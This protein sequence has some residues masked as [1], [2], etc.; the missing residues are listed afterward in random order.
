MTPPSGVRQK[1]PPRRRPH[2]PRVTGRAS[3]AGRAATSPTRVARMHRPMA[4]PLRPARTVTHRRASAQGGAPVADAQVGPG[5][6]RPPRPSRRKP[7]RAAAPSMAAA[8]APDT[9]PAVVAPAAVVVRA[10]SSSALT[11][12]TALV[13]PITAITA[14]EV[15]G[16]KRGRGRKSGEGGGQQTGHRQL[17]NLH[18]LVW[19]PLE[20]SPRQPRLCRWV[21]GVWEWGEVGC[22]VSLTNCG[23]SDPLILARRRHHMPA[24]R[25]HRP[26]A[27]TRPPHRAAPPTG[28]RRHHMRQ[29]ASPRASRVATDQPRRSPRGELPPSVSGGGGR[30][31]VAIAGAGASCRHPPMVH[32]DGSARGRRLRP[33]RPGPKQGRAAGRRREGE[34]TLVGGRRREQAKGAGRWRGD[35]LVRH[36][37][38]EG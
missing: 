21:R 15:G 28:W 5:V 23:P 33:T 6:G 13:A 24:R 26:V 20:C 38:M 14:T 35:A 10:S 29:A 36:L 34:H 3:H 8:G 37:S 2:R 11:P 1:R 31:G 19:P 18:R 32:H 12:H 9:L 4:V 27:T 22:P 30:P 17:F 7:H 25:H 16:V